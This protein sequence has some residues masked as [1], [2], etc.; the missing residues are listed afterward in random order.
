MAGSLEPVAE[1]AGVVKRRGGAL[2]L[3]GVSLALRAGE[4]TALLGANGAGKSTAVGPLIGR[5]SADRGSVRLLGGDPQSRAARER[6]G[7]MLQQ[8]GAPRGLKVAELIDLFRGYYPAPRTRR[9]VVALAGLEGLERRRCTALSGGQQRRVQFALALCGR[10]DL[11]ILDEPTAGMDVE[12]R[13]ALWSSV[14]SEA[15]RGAAV[16][17]TTHHLEEAEALADRVV[18]IDRGRIIADAPPH[19]LKAGVAAGAVRCR[20]S[21]GDAELAGLPGVTA[22][23]R[24]GGRVVLLTS[25]PPETLRELLARDPALQDFSVTTAS[26]EDALAHLGR[27]ESL[28]DTLETAA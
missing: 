17:L 14:R 15:A 20:T 7:V 24:E 8:A 1:L 28:A 3:A 12:A 4:V 26:L 16:L 25:A 27:G 23:T 9:E 6:L 21:L 19:A 11:L 18:V 13:R 5:L 2:A 22:V 10:P